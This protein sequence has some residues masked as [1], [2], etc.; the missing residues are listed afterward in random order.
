MGPGNKEVRHT[1]EREGRDL[2]EM[3]AAV[4]ER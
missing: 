1:G 2:G 4:G 3:T